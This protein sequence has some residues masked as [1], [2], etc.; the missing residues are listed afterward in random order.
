MI[1]RM[2]SKAKKR[3]KP[4]DLGRRNDPLDTQMIGTDVKMNTAIRIMAPLRPRRMMSS[5]FCRRNSTR[6]PNAPGPLDLHGQHHAL[7]RQRSGAAKR[8][9]SIGV[10]GSL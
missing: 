4:C 10:Y 2:D 8:R 7:V 5:G 1:A 6:Q 9:Q 3:E